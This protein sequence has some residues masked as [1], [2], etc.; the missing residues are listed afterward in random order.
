LLKSIVKAP[1][2]QYGSVLQQ[3]SAVGA[4]NLSVQKFVGGYGGPESRVQELLLIKEK[5]ARLEESVSQSDKKSVFDLM[6]TMEDGQIELLSN[7]HSL[8]D[9]LKSIGLSH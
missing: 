7:V 4:D 1:D 9:A 5:K 8:D 2:S 6:T 3:W